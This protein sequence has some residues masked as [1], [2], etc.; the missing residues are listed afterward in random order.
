MT[1][2]VMQFDYEGYQDQPARH[3]GP[4]GL[5]RGHLP[6]AHR[7]RQRG[8]A[9]RQSQGRR[10]A[11][12]A[13]VRRLQAAAHA[14]LH[15]RQQVRSRRRGSAQ[16]DQRRRGRPRHR[17][18]IPSPGRSTRD[19][20]SSACTI[21]GASASIDCS[22]AARTTVR[23]RATAEVAIARRSRDRRAARRG[24][25]RAARARHRAARRGGTSRSS[26][27]ALLAG[28]LS[29]VFFGSALTNFGVEPFLR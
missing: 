28:A 18:S 23:A 4:R 6:H 20:A 7:R 22:S 25:A 5:L 21:G 13:A 1:S 14:D 24:G 2:S 19:G 26:H 3:A 16:A 15:R 12:A 17:L 11:H 27:E 9:A 29:P 8:D 10:G